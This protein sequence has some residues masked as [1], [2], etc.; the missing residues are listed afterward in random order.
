MKAPRKNNDRRG[1]TLLEVMTAATLSATLMASSFVV[2]RSSHAAWLAHETD[3]NA[4]GE[5]AG[6]LRHFLQQTRQAAGV[7]AISAA[8]DTSGALT[9]LRDDGTTLTW[10]H[11]GSAVT[12]QEDG[13]AAEP[14][15]DG[16]LSLRFEGIEADG[17][18]LT[19]EPSDVHAIRASVTV[20]A[21]TG[22]VRTVSTYTW[23]RS[24]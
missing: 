10:E 11:S 22:G 16:I 2:L 13:G 4:A 20:D 19:N 15:A 5:A 7:N 8:A 23:V 12:V 14:L 3:M 1:V 17:S 18:T 21:P 24:W 9:I 6:V